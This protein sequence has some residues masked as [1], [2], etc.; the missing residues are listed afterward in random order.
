MKKIDLNDLKKEQPFK[1]PEGYF[2]ELP[3][4]IQSRAVDSGSKTRIWEIPAIRWAAIPAMI[5][6]IVVFILL[7]NGEQVGPDELLA[8][9]S[10]EELVAYLEYSEVSTTE[11]LDMVDQPE[12]LFEDSEA[13][14]F[15]DNLSEEDMELLLENYDVLL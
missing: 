4:L 1:A 2:E 12:M 3:G 9:V 10:T 7:P 15:G 5:I 14:L 11:L 13:D 8:E 6:A